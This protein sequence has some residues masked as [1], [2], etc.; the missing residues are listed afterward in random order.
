MKV[1]LWHV[2][3]SW[4]TS[5]VQ[6]RHEYLLPLVPDRGPDGRGRAHSW[7][8][9]ASAREVPPER[10]RDEQ[11]DVVVIQRPHEAELLRTWTGLRVGVDVPAVYLEHN[12]PTEHAV[13]SVHPVAGDP[14]LRGLPLVHVTRFNAMA[15]DA[16]GGESFVVEHGVPDPGQLYDGRD[17]SLAAVVN[18]PVRRSRVAGTDLLLALA[19]DVPTHVYGMDTDQLSTAAHGLG[20]PLPPDRCH[21][22]DQAELHRRLGSHRAYLHP[23]R[24]T[25][26]GL[27]LVEAMTIGMPVLALSTTEAP[28]AVPATAGVVTNDLGLLRR[29]ALRW[30]AHPE[31]ARERGVAAR[32]HALARF[33]LPRFLDEWDRLL[34]EVLNR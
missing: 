20:P 18:E 31:E 21:D 15:W 14:G 30:L 16:S 9:P 19:A 2:H 3:G 5:F 4:T 1:L 25:S 33:G 28:E 22:L 34:K 17:G 29:T 27:A 26:L 23:Y 11:P 8:W 7:D 32:D 24:W 12:A 10:L 6:G 13:R